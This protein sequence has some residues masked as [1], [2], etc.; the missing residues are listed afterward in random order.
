MNIALSKSKR[1]CDQK[2]RKWLK[3]MA[4]ENPEHFAL[5]WEGKINSWLAWISKSA[6]RS[7]PDSDQIVSVF[8]KIDEIMVLLHSCGEGMY[9]KH[10]RTTFALLTNQC[11]ISFSRE[12]FPKI[13]KYKKKR[14]P[15]MLS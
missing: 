1:R 13:L 14:Y 10:A 8:A 4:R 11:H 6:G 15:E 5:I 3:R 9:D 7:D 12:A 2:R